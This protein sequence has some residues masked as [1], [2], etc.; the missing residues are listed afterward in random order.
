MNNIS[1]WN[2][3]DKKNVIYLGTGTS[4]N[5]SSYEGYETFTTDNFIVGIKSIST[6]ATSWCFSDGASS[7][8]TTT[9]SCIISSSYDKNTGILTISNTQPNTII[10]PN[11]ISSIN[12]TTTVFA[13][14]I[15]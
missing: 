8:G 2:L 4:F 14:L 13:Y 6:T 1:Y 9:Q 11:N 3:S 10:T 12:S 7:P 15:Y 5:I